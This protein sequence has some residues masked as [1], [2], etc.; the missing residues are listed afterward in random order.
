MIEAYFKGIERDY[1]VNFVRE[2]DFLGT[3]GSLKL[4]EKTISETFI[5]SNCDI[6]VK[7]HFE[8]VLKL[9]HQQDASLTILS[10]VQHYEIP[11]GVINLK[12][13]GD[14]ADILEK[15]EYTFTINTGVYVLNKE[16][17]QFIPEGSRTDMTD[18][19]KTLIENGK[20]IAT[21]PVNEREYLDIGQWKEYKKA[22]NY[23]RQHEEI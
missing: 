1:E 23:F 3:A 17:L 9:H 6:I 16:A 7:A 22:V 10:S 14:F 8:N 4:L 11:Y 12:D 5:V 21:Y 19:I 18:L 15:P 20:K 2:E 13:G